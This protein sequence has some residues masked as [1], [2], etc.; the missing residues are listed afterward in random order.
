M[1]GNGLP[2]LIALVFE[3]ASDPER[4]DDLVA[5]ISRYFAADS[6]IL[7]IWPK[8]AP[9]NLL[10]AAVGLTEDEAKQW[11]TEDEDELRRALETLAPETTVDL[12]VRES[13]AGGATSDARV[14][15]VIEGNDN[16]VFA[17]LL[18]R[19]APGLFSQADY[20]SLAELAGFMRRAA[21]IN[22]RWVRLFAEQRAARVLL[23]SAPRGILLLGQRG[24]ATYLNDEA[25]R[26]CGADDGITLD[27]DQL[28]FTDA[29]AADRLDGFLEQARQTGENGNHLPAIG[30]NVHRPSQA[31]PYQLI[32]YGLGRDP[33]RAPLDEKEGLAV[34]MLHDPSVAEVPDE[35]LLNTYFGL[36][37]AE[38]QLTQ[39]LCEGHTLPD[40]AKVGSI[41]VNTARTHLRSVFQKVGVHSQ[42]ALVQR[43]TQSL[44]FAHP[45]D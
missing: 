44:H 18:R 1:P 19:K 35:R 9:Q 36:T 37:P 42:A 27:Q 39:A 3:C 32:G 22:R 21:I 20:D 25:R 28:R 2:D 40:A 23:D 17:L 43:V 11:F 7:A 33:R 24:Q 10:A 38:S 14:G 31:P 16:N 5:A 12:P 8:W 4:L 15:V 41:S 6:A 13:G 26:I 45:L 30:M 29:A 34:A